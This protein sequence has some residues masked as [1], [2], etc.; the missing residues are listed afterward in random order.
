MHVVRARNSYA[1]R[2]G[3]YVPVIADGGIVH[4]KDIVIALALG[5]DAVM[6]GRYF[7][8]MEESPAD[9]VTINNRVM[10][11]YWGEGSPRARDW[12]AVR[13][14]QA[15]F[16]EGVEGFVEF[17][18]KLRDNLDD[19]LVKIRAS[20]S[21]CGVATIEDLHQR[22]ELELVSALSIREGQVHDIYLPGPEALYGS[23]KWGD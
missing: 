3:I 21:T 2:T 9:K 8:R 10:K 23:T 4:A 13:Y 11:P 6:M 7:A 1:E 17:A 20:M 19:T 15:S 14:Q 12:K 5:A 18:G 16:A 22:A